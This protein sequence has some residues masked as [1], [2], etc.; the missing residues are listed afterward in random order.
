MTKSIDSIKVNIVKVISSLEDYDRLSKIASYIGVS[1]FD[2]PSTIF[3]EGKAIE[4]IS[5]P[6]FDDLF[7]S[8]GSKGITYEQLPQVDKGWEFSLDELLAAL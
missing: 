2:K 1:N 5:T 3:E 7:T 6:D 4:V 8:Q